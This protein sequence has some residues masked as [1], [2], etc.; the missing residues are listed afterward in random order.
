MKIWSNNFSPRE[1]IWFGLKERVTV[2]K[3]IHYCQNIV[4]QIFAGYEVYFLNIQN[5][6]DIKVHRHTIR[7]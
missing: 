3:K 1:R 5:K 4:K 7:M 6:E 2:I